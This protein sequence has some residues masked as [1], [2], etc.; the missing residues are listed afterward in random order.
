MEHCPNCRAKQPGES[1]CRRCGMDLSLLNQIQR[2]SIRLLGEALG[3]LG[4][5]DLNQTVSALRRAERLCFDP[6]IPYL[7]GFILQEGGLTSK[8]GRPEAP[9]D[10]NG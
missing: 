1:G 9:S 3:H 5:G 4:E 6:V 8:P 10:F 7:L 2:Q